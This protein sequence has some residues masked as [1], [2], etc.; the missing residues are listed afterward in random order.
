VAELARPLEHGLIISE[1]LP[2]EKLLE[3][4]R[5]TPASE[6]LVVGVDG[7]SRGV[8]ATSDLAKALGLRYRD[9]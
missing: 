2:G 6:Y 5:R 8:L 3:T 7:V 1:D 4:V 9:W